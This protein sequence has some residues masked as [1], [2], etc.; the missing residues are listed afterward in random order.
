MEFYKNLAYTI[1]AVLF[2][3]II[4]SCFN[5]QK[6]LVQNLSFRE[7]TN[8]NS[9]KEGFTSRN[10]LK[11]NKFNSN[12]NLLKMIENKLRGLTEELG[13]NDGKKEVKSLLTST[14]KILNLECAKCMM[15]M[16]DDNKDAKSINVENLIEEGNDT[17][18]IKCKKYTELSD[19]ISSM[20]NNL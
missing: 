1:L 17:N 19:T 4:F 20:I 16:L 12:D 15:N 8:L 2:I 10:K 6:R 7:V 13:G 14:K 11:E 3:I 18:C 9:N 5:Y